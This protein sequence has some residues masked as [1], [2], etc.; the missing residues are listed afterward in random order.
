VTIP[1]VLHLEGVRAGYGIIDVL[2]GVDLDVHAGEVLALLG[3]NGAGKT[4]TIH[5]AAG[6][7]RP[8]AGRLLLQGR[9]VTG[10]SS[11]ALARAGRPWELHL[12]GDSLPEHRDIEHDLRGRSASGEL[13]G[14]VTFH[15]FVDDTDAVYDQI[16]VS[17]VPSV[18]PEEFSLVA[19]EGQVRGCA[20]VVTGPG[21]VAEVVIDGITGLVVPPSDPDALAVALTSLDDDRE[22]LERLARA[23]ADRVRERFSEEVYQRRMGELLDEVMERTA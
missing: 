15:G 2:H 10:V 6:Q 21:G 19:A 22:M 12:F 23:G 4:T 5:V 1:P 17:V 11:D 3:P 13:P 9:D 16:D 8:S 14:P 7:I 20:T 18:R